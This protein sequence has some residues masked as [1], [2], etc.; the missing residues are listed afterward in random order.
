M[1]SEHFSVAQKKYIMAK[2]VILIAGDYI[3]CRF[4]SSH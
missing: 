4:I 1:I 2:L 3:E